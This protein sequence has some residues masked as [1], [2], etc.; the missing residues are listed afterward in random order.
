MYIPYKYDNTTLFIY[1]Y[2]RNI[3]F[4]PMSVFISVSVCPLFS[5]L[6]VVFHII[7]ANM[8]LSWKSLDKSADDGRKNEKGGTAD[9]RGGGN[10]RK[11]PITRGAKERES[12][13]SRAS[14]KRR[15][16][17]IAHAR[18]ANRVCDCGRTSRRR[19]GILKRSFRKPL[20]GEKSACTRTARDV[21]QAMRR[22]GSRHVTPMRN[23]GR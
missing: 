17:S 4:C 2:V 21:R 22:F 13:R 7:H 3:I 19:R 14:I 15:R 6:S 18:D 10:E 5:L 9:E 8:H 16:G 20:L 11:G 1:I 23:Q 12:D